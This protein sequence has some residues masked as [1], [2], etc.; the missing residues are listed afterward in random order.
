MTSQF[1]A[2]NTGMTLER[3]RPKKFLKRE[4][5]DFL[6][7]V[8]S[9]FWVQD[10]DKSECRGLVKEILKHKLLPGVKAEMIII[11]VV[12]FQNENFSYVTNPRL[13]D[14]TWF[15]QQAFGPEEWNEAYRCICWCERELV[16]VFNPAR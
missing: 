14:I 1:R 3:Q 7:I 15:L 2:K 10:L 16:T 9:H 12:R 4:W 8:C 13:D 6:D 11:A 5:S